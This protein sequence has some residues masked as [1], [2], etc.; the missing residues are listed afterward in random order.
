MYL[1]PQRQLDRLK[2]DF[3]HVPLRQTVES[4]LEEAM[5]NVLNRSDLHPQEKVK[6]YTALLQRYLVM[7]KQGDLETNT[8]T[9]SIPPQL[10]PEAPQ[11][12]PQTP[13]NTESV[14]DVMTSEVLKNLPQRSRKNAEYILQKMQDAPDVAS[15]DNTGA[16]IFQGAPI[17][18]THIYDL[19]KTVTGPQGVSRRGPPTGWREFLNT[20]AE[21]NIPLSTIPN[22]HL[23]SE[24]A[25]LKS[26]P[27]PFRT[28]SRRSGPIE[29]ERF[30]PKAFLDWINY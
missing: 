7:V 16:F 10:H 18:G 5:K 23:Q 19:V 30:T 4:D 26:Q 8:L 14:M 25:E 29:K 13:I 6:H 15:W 17:P 22:R 9:L 28:P 24:I 21:L 2:D 3:R 27:T 20:I 12:V 1:V 11:T